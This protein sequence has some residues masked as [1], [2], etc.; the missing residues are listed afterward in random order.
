MTLPPPPRPYQERLQGMPTQE[1][2]LEGLRKLL[3]KHRRSPLVVALADN[4]LD[5]WG[6][7]IPPPA[8]LPPPQQQQR[9]L[10][11]APPS[12]PHRLGPNYNRGGGGYSYNSGSRRGG[13]RG[14]S[15]VG[16]GGTKRSHTG[17]PAQYRPAKNPR[18]GGYGRYG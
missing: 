14:D 16:A 7:Y 15:R 9:H 13:Y 5:G 11:R 3:V 2:V 6:L 8:A 12:R 1:T 18:H 4:T 17:P 10:L